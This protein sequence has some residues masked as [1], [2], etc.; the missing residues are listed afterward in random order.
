MTHDVQNLLGKAMTL[1]TLPDV[2]YRLVEMIDDP[3]SSLA[4]VA[5]LIAQDT[6]LTA[7]LLR[8]ANSALF[9][10]PARIGNIGQAVTVV[11][12]QQIK[13]LSLACHVTHVFQGIPPRLI[14]TDDFWRHALAVGLAARVIATHRHEVNV[15][16]YYALGLLHDLGRLVI[17]LQAPPAAERILEHC[18]VAPALMEP[19]ER[20]LLATDHGEIGGALLRYW[21]LPDC[22]WEPVLHHHH[23]ERATRHPEAAA[24]LHVADIMAHTLEY[25]S[26]GERFVPPLS[27]QAWNLLGLDPGHLDRMMAEV[28]EQ[29]QDTLQLLHPGIH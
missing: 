29:F 20:E 7:Q 15:E 3:M 16:R 2:Y 21:R 10:F 18:R 24:L 11:G 28:E 1:P 22:L 17:Y 4:D 25:G 6:A 13:E 12:M 23:P 8:I 19:A 26:S 5:R 9:G 27:A 14:D